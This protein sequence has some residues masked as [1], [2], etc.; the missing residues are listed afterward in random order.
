MSV[1]S[2]S[3]HDVDIA[4][5]VAFLRDPSSYPDA[6]ESVEAVETH[7]AWIFLAGRS[8]YKMKKPVK[9]S[10]LDFSTLELRRDDCRAEVLLNRRLAEGVYLGTL[11]LTVSQGHHLHLGGEGRVVEWLVHMRRLDH[12]R[13][14]D[15]RIREGTL[16]L[17]DVQRAAERLADFY[18]RT[19]PEP[20]TP[21]EYR[22][23]FEQGVKENAVVLSKAAYGL[24]TDLVERLARVQ[25]SFLNERGAQLE[26]RARDGRIIE[27]HG[28]LRPE[29]IC[30]EEKPV[31]F[32]CLEFNRDFRIV[33]PVDELSFLSMEC[34]ALGNTSVGPA[35]LET[36]ESLTGDFPPPGLIVF[37][38]T[39]RACLR[40]KLAVWHLDDDG[41]TDRALWRSRA[42]RYLRLADSYAV[43]I[44]EAYAGM[45]S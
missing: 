32:D 23:R 17:N 29:H 16:H 22:S 45:A 40:A 18:V 15:V 30:L 35:V 5:K 25:I 38:K 8:A 27:S 28:D 11:P 19:P 41:R 43:K 26:R 2:G 13:M 14:L 36:Y 7:M 39:Y 9:L 10:F 44:S 31:V 6:S 24:Q 1:L 42:D 12:S 33:D 37:Y 3:L 4:S 21:A 34:D 20:I